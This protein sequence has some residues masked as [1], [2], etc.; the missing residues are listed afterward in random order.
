M[1][2]NSDGS[3]GKFTPNITSFFDDIFGTQFFRAYCEG[4]ARH[5][6]W[7]VQQDVK[8]LVD[9]FGTEEYFVRELE[10]FMKD[11]SLQRAALDPGS[12]YWIGNQHDIHTPYLFGEAG[13]PDLTQKWVRWTLKNRFST[14]IDGLDG[15]DDG[16]TLS[17]WYVF[18]ALGFYPDAG[19]EFYFIGSPAVDSA[20]ITLEN[21]ETLKITV[22]NQGEKNI[23][24]KSV[25]LNGRAVDSFKISHADIAGGGELVFEMTDKI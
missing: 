24:V 13:R 4:G 8:G 2:R 12:G 10:R 17:S 18:S 25:T 16:G 5:W 19:T 20:Q 7:S 15:N 23:Y 9:L 11:A 6:R 21:G 14:D 3:F 22:S 1:P